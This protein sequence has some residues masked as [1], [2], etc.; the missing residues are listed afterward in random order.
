MMIQT[1]YNYRNTKNGPKEFA[2]TKLSLKSSKRT[3]RSA[4]WPLG[5]DSDVA[6]GYAY[7]TIVTDRLSYS[8]NV[9]DLQ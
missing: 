9:N 7:N 1:I 2:K 8:V 4:Y 6:I 3:A 5:D